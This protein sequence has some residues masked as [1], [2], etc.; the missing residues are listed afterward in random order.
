MSLEPTVAQQLKP[1]TSTVASAGLGIPIGIVVVSI[2]KRYAGLED[3]SVEEAT[4]I[5]AICSFLTGYFFHGG[6][7]ETTV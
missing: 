4:A 2:L 1:S 5:G 3:I 7:S 6:R